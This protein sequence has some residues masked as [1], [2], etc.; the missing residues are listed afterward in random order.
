[1][2]NNKMEAIKLIKKKLNKE[3][4]L[5]YNEIAE[6][7]GYHPKYIFKLK[8]QIENDTI[9]LE[10][11]NKNRKP[12]NALTEAEKLKIRSLY[13]KSTVSIRK[14]CKFYNTRS[15]SCIYNAI[16]EGEKKETSE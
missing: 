16:K 6:I 7:C 13:A 8:K 3:S 10:H 11:G 1:M 9:S 12:S 4:Y 14:F 5:T 2:K 15:Y